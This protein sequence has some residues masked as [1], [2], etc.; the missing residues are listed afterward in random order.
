MVLYGVHFVNT[1]LHH[2]VISP[3]TGRLSMFNGVTNRDPFVLNFVGTTIL[4]LLQKFSK[5]KYDISLLY[6]F[7]FPE[8]CFYG[9]VNVCQ[10]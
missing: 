5:K 1:I 9:K 8:H 6:I 4:N 7:L 3:P 2:V 10:Q